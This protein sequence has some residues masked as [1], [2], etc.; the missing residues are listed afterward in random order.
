MDFEEEKKS[1]FQKLTVAIA[2]NYDA[3]IANAILDAK[4]KNGKSIPSSE[5][6]GMLSDKARREVIVRMIIVLSLGLNIFDV[7]DGCNISESDY[8]SLWVYPIGRKAVIYVA[9]RDL[10]SIPDSLSD[11]MKVFCNL[12]ELDDCDHVSSQYDDNTI[13]AYGIKFILN[14]RKCIESEKEDV[15]YENGKAESISQF[16]MSMAQRTAI[17]NAF[18][19]EATMEKA[20]SANQVLMQLK[21]MKQYNGIIK[22]YESGLKA[23]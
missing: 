21:R 8:E 3:L 11:E 13:V 7:A 23:S 14:M 4:G 22:A 17:I 16:G 2:Y 6:I 10:L 19:S 1:V 18:I 15:F 9:N 20:L 5:Y 12:Y